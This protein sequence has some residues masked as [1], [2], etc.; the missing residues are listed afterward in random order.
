MAKKLYV[1]NLSYSTTEEAL[2]DLFAQYGEIVSTAVIKDRATG[3]SKG[4]GFVELADEAAAEKAITDLNGKEFEGR[5]IR[6]NVA[7]EKKPRS[8]FGEGGYDRG[9][10]Y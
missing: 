6:V 8:R 7:E 3:Q 10:R 1:G 5:R 4:F 2:S 9:G